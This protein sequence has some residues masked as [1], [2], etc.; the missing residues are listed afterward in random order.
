MPNSEIKTKYELHAPEGINYS[1]SGCG[2]CCHD[3]IVPMTEEDY[4]RVSVLK[5][6]ELIPGYTGSQLFREAKK[7]ESEGTA[8]THV[9]MKSKEGHCP[10]LVNKL[11][12]IHGKHG[13]DVKPII[14]QLFPYCFN[15]TPTGVF[16]TVS[17]R[18]SAVLYNQGTPLAEQMD[19]LEDRLAK[20][21]ELYPGKTP[22]WDA[23]RLSVNQN[24][25]WSDY[26]E[27]EKE[28]FKIL[29]DS[30]RSL[31]ARMLACSD[32]L[33]SKANTGSGA[34]ASSGSASSDTAA[35]GGGPAQLKKLDRYLLSSL[36][37]LYFP[38]SDSVSRAAMTFSVMRFVNKFIF[39]SPNLK[40]ATRS[41]T[42]EE[43]HEFPWP[44]DDKDISDLL[45]RFFYSR[46][47]GKWY[48]GGGYWQLSLITGFHHLIICLAVLKLQAKSSAIARGANQVQFIDVAHSV[49][50]LEEQMSEVEIGAYAAGLFELLMFSPKRLRRI[51]SAV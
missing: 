39:G 2:R 37:A 31:E 16:V 48:F 35:A 47:F 20:Y 42:L 28:L 43:L 24:I 33:L 15:E 44:D 27:W 3:I 1:C 41:F 26:L 51:L 23:I 14:C 5:M 50:K 34:S 10:F 13:S 45:Y 18:S 11:C 21:K 7:H 22:N 36:H 46:L 32:F 9:I 19:V 38:A 4:E 49:R 29:A 6:D 40:T 8:Y 17:F 12:S 25:Q 30:S